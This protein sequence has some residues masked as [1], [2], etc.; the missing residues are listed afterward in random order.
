M[1]NVCFLSYIESNI[2]YINIVMHE[3]HLCD[4][5]VSVHVL[6]SGLVK[7]TTNLFYSPWFDPIEART[8][9]YL[10]RVAIAY[11]YTTDAVLYDV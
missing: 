10:T 4:L 9:I 3:N 2:S 8:H 7:I 6:S 11:H 1:T 5:M